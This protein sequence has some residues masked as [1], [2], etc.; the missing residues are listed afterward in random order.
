MSEVAGGQ[1]KEEVELADAELVD[2]A[3]GQLVQGSVD[4]PQR[5]LLDVVSR[6]PEPYVQSFERNGTLHIKFWDMEDFTHYILLHKEQIERDRQEVVWLKNAYPRAHYFL[7]FI[8]VK[9]GNNAEAIRWLD[10]G[11]KLQP[12]QPLFLVEKAKALSGLRRFEESLA[13]YAEVANLGPELLRSIRATAVRGMGFQLIELG[14]LDQAEAAFHASLK[15]DP[16]SEIAR[17]ELVYIAHLRRG[18]APVESATVVTPGEKP[19]CA[20]CG[21]DPKQ[22]GGKVFEQDGQMIWLCRSCV[23]RLEGKSEKRWW[24]FWK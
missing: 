24:Q 8:Q 19:Q 2:Q 17:H 21:G 11:R 20:S 10:A 23:T 22:S 4:G 15:L 16:G 6:T 1:P 9:L 13:L 5:M 12:D 18:G 3:L 14:V 7:G